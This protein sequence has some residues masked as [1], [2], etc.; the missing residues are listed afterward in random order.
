MERKLKQLGPAYMTSTYRYSTLRRLLRT[1]DKYKEVVTAFDI[2][3]GTTVTPKLYADFLN[4]IYSLE[5]EKLVAK[6]MAKVRKGGRHKANLA[7]A[8]AGEIQQNDDDEPSDDPDTDEEEANKASLA[9]R[10]KQGGRGRGDGGRGRGDGRG[11]GRGAPGGPPASTYKH[12]ASCSK[13]CGGH[14]NGDQKKVTWAPNANPA[15]FNPTKQLGGGKSTKR[16]YQK[17]NM[18]EDFQT[19]LEF[20]DWQ[21]YD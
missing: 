4:Q 13:K 12:V 5:S 20:K 1:D 14:C 21:H 16:Q 6:K 7:E 3:K 10:G 9:K 8:M 17:A 18:A 19:F 15:H 2:G 11:R